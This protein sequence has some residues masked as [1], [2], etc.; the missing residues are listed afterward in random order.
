M[1]ILF[2]RYFDEHD[3]KIYNALQSIGDTIVVVPDNLSY[4]KFFE[5]RNLILTYEYFLKSYQNYDYN[6][7]ISYAFPIK[8][9]Q[10]I[11]Q[12]NE[13]YSINFHPAPL[14]KYRG[15]GNYIKAILEELD[16]WAVS[17]HHMDDIIDNGDLIKVSKFT[18]DS[19][20]ETYHSLEIRTFQEMWKLYLE[21]LEM[22][23]EDKVPKYPNDKTDVEYLTRRELQNQ[24]EIHLGDS[25]EIIEKKIRAFWRPPYKGAYITIGETQY[26]LVNQV[27]LDEISKKSKK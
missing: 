10:K 7:I 19:K 13:G 11:L 24:K 1:N 27:I 8:I 17:A 6:L 12:R 18:I 25:P 4:D 20:K 14:P 9:P 26:T 23:K 2:I 15:A 16:E 22:V 5:S 21:V 3:Y